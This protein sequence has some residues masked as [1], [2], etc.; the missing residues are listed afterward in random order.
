VDPA[1]R[2]HDVY[3][4][5]G[6]QN[7]RQT[8][9]NTYLTSKRIFMCGQHILHTA[10]SI[11]KPTGRFRSVSSGLVFLRRPK[12]RSAVFC[13][14][15]TGAPGFRFW[16]C[17]QFLRPADLGFPGFRFP[18]RFCRWIC[19]TQ[20]PGQRELSAFSFP[21]RVRILPPR[22]GLCFHRSRES[23]CSSPPPCRAS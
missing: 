2:Y 16:R 18:C 15:A 19:S 13:F 8:H 10:S 17:Q 1:E 7:D 11:F 3:T 20:I 23:R 4:E 22:L 9:Q 5:F 12:V 14:T 6:P 21:L